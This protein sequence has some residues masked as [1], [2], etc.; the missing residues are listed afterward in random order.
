MYEK[1]SKLI[2]EKVRPNLMLHGGDIE[3]VDVKD[4]VVKVRLKGACS[5]C[6]MSRL[7]FVTLVEK[8]IKENMP[9]IKAVEV[10]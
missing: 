8:T 4:N 7:T 9:E 6:P 3:L 5:G 10:V 2:N 1:V